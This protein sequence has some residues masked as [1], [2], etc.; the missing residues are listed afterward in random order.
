MPEN[1]IHPTIATNLNNIITDIMTEVIPSNILTPEMTST[2]RNLM[3]HSVI[4]LITGIVKEITPLI[5]QTTVESLR[6]SSLAQV[7]D[8]IESYEYEFE[9]FQKVNGT[10]MDEVLEQR[11]QVYYN[12]R[13]CDA[14]LDAYN[15]CLA[16]EPIILPKKF[17]FVSYV[18]DEDNFYSVTKFE[19]QR[20]LCECE[21]LN[22][23]RAKCL[24]EIYELD[25]GVEEF[26]KG[27]NCS[28]EVEAIA[29]VRWKELLTEDVQR[30]D[31]QWI[32]K[33]N[34]R[35]VAFEKDKLFIEKQRL[36]RL[37]SNR[38]ITEY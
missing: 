1:D 25:T 3:M 7:T 12:Y 13:H 32:Y 17:R 18:T 26:V 14:L 10:Y 34:N 5:I 29:L 30:I 33:I 19:L 2:L 37:K 15:D 20:F 8:D 6:E 27:C 9:M 24:S 16:T 31:K 11:A 35:K 28:Q 38:E 21:T 22:S 4:E 23:R 36:E